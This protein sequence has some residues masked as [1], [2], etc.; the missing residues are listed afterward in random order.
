MMGR[1]VMVVVKM[2][3]LVAENGGVV[4]RRKFRDDDHCNGWKTGFQNNCV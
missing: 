4:Q 2:G 1:A 3:S